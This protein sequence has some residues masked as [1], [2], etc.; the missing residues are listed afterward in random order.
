VATGVEVPK[1]GWNTVTQL[2]ELLESAVEDDFASISVEFDPELG[3]PTQINLTCD[4]N[5]LDCG[6]IIEARNLVPIFLIDN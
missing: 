4:D 6:L 5:A 3:Y 2:F 1:A